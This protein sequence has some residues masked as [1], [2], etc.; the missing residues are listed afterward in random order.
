MGA[1]AVIIGEVLISAISALMLWAKS[2][3]LTEEETRK[4]ISEAVKQIEESKPENLPYV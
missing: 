1:E 2:K 3:G 4:A